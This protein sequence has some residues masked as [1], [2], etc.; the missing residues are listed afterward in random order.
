MSCQYIA[1]T[2]ELQ[3]ATEMGPNNLSLLLF[4]YLHGP[5]HS[6]LGLVWMDQCNTAEVKVYDSQS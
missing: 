2:R 4:M 5:L 3:P 1:Y 6:E